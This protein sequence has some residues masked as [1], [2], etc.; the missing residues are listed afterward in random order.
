MEGD[1]GFIYPRVTLNLRQ[2]SCFSLLIARTER[3]TSPNLLLK[4]LPFTKPKSKYI[5][6]ACM[7][8]YWLVLPSCHGRNIK[9][10]SLRVF[11]PVSID[12]IINGH[13][14]DES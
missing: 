14:V 5:Y 12:C 1:T 10:L 2:A 9:G 7:H 4:N 6:V 13:S 8:F 3:Y 11:Q